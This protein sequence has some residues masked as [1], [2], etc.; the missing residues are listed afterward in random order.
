MHFVSCRLQGRNR[1][2]I[3][4]DNLPFFHDQVFLYVMP[5]DRGWRTR[6][7]QWYRK[8][9]FPIQQGTCRWSCALGW[10]NGTDTAE[11]MGN[12]PR[13]RH[14]GILPHSRKPLLHRPKH[15]RRRRRI[16]QLQVRLAGVGWGTFLL[17]SFSSLLL[18]LYSFLFL[19]LIL[20]FSCPRSFSFSRSRSR[21]KIFSRFSRHRFYARKWCVAA[22]MY[23]FVVWFLSRYRV[24]RWK[25]C[26]AAGVC[27]FSDFLISRYM[28]FR[29]KWCVA[30]WMYAFVM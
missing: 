18:L 8:Y 17:S 16:H 2:Y 15:R 23:A 5:F 12:G 26:V 30:A 11:E 21:C 7:V 13:D 27:C 3:E 4:V 1:F 19:R 9:N 25:E 29:A 20:F 24:F 22:W 6:T 28:L 10:D 14:M